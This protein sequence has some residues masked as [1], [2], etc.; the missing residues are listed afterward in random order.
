MGSNGTTGHPGTKQRARPASHSLTP[1][2]RPSLGPPAVP[3]SLGRSSDPLPLPL[4]VSSTASVTGSP[5]PQSHPSLTH[6][7]HTQPNA[8]SPRTRT[9][10]T[11]LCPPLCRALRESCSCLLSGLSCSFPAGLQGLPAALGEQLEPFRC[12]TLPSPS[13]PPPTA[14]GLPP[15][16]SGHPSPLG[17]IPGSRALLSLLHLFLI[18]PSFRPHSLPRRPSPSPSTEDLPPTPK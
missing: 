15:T 16:R 1:S 7:T 10:F 12:L 13:H 6:T 14:A 9:P 4:T 11:H 18:C 17:Q 5:R 2:S 8:K 3:T